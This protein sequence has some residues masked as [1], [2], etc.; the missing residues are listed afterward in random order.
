MNEYVLI[1]QNRKMVERFLRRSDGIWAYEIFT[2]VKSEVLF[3]SI[4]TKLKFDEIYDLV[5]FEEVK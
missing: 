1:D 3:S 4:E 2:D 5:E